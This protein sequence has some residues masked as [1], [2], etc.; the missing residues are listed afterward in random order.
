MPQTT[1]I[2]V[3]FIGGPFDGHRQVVAVPLED[4]AT[5]VA[6]PIN[7]NVFRM[8]DGQGRG[9]AAPSQTVALYEL[10]TDNGGRYFYLGSRPAVEFNLEN[11]LV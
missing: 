2:P 5:P 3:E 9:P 7:E 4:L 1:A 11:W 8:L 10:R 6:L